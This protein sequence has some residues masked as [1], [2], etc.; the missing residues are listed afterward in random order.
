MIH[1]TK[2]KC[3]ENQPESYQLLQGLFFKWGNIL[4]FVLDK[5][6][7]VSPLTGKVF[8]TVGLNAAACS[9]GC[10]RI[11]EYIQTKI[12]PAFSHKS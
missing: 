11:Y 2:R 8:W 7:A 3:F 10:T 4:I 5:A 6:E 12:L 9:L 1:K